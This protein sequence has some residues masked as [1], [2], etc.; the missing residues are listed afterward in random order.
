M[1]SGDLSVFPLLPVMQMLL[2]SGK[3]GRFTVNHARGGELWLSQGEV[4]HARSGA[5]TGERALQLLC[6]VD[7]GTFVFKTGI[8]APARSL[9]LRQDQAMHH[10]LT[11]AEAWP[12]LLAA[13]PDWSRSP[14]FTPLWND[15]Q[16][17]TR[18]QYRALHLLTLD[19]PLRSVM[20]L[21]EL[22]PRALLE[23]YRPYL[24]GG[25]IELR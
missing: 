15:Q 6:S 16:P 1:I 10:M 5:L 19:L 8:E 12:S 23:L 7:K 14:R 17:V 22:A 13:F 4:V 21:T 11:E 24:E 18:D 20:D 2:S 3:G 25:Q 9:Q